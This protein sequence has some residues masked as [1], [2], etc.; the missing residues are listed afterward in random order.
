MQRP[1]LI[2]AQDFVYFAKHVQAF[3]GGGRGV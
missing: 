2:T 1:A 3:V